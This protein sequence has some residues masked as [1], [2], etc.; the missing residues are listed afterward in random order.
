MP[1]NQLS[2]KRGLVLVEG[3]ILTAKGEIKLLFHNRGKK[4]YFWNT[5][6]LLVLP[7]DNISRS[8]TMPCV[9]VSGKPQP[10]PSRTTSD[11]DPSRIKFQF[12]LPG[13]EPQLAKYFL[14]VK[15][16]HNG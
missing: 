7:W 1:L 4:E 14:K 16:I 15:G 2:E 12:I 9:K 6:D 11:T 10:N 8:V 5:R 13:K 3:L